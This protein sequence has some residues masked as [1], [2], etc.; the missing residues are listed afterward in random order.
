M[1]YSFEDNSTLQTLRTQFDTF[2]NLK[3]QILICLTLH[4]A[5]LAL[6]LGVFIIRKGNSSLCRS[7]PWI[8]PFISFAFFF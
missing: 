5:Y 2:I 6:R 7:K 1:H 3:K 8:L 4:L